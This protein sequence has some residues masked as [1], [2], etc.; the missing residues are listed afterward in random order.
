MQQA[1]N[2]GKLVN[3]LEQSGSLS[4]V[5]PDDGEDYDA[6]WVPTSQLK[7]APKGKP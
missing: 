7:P 6:V 2:H 4:R 5:A 1:L 3:V